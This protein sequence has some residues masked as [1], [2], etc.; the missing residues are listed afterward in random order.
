M[1]L[2]GKGLERVG[3]RKAV[4]GLRS[5]TNCRNAW[6]S[7]VQDDEYCMRQSHKPGMIGL[8]SLFKMGDQSSQ[9]L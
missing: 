4:E 8:F 6:S 2:V 1:E 9:H 5:A 7:A 3:R